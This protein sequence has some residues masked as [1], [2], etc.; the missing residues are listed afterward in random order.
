VATKPASFCLLIVVDGEC[1]KAIFTDVTPYKS[2]IGECLEL[3]WRYLAF[4]QL[5][6]DVVGSDGLPKAQSRGDVQGN[7]LVTF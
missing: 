6:L 1:G 4:L 5:K 7:G 3:T 2:I